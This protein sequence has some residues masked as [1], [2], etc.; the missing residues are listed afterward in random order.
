[1][2]FAAVARV[3]ESR[4]IACGVR[5]EINFGLVPGSEL[6]LR[7]TICYE[8]RE[9]GAQ[10]AIDNVAEDPLFCDHQTPRIYGF[11]SYISIPIIRQNGEFFG[12]LCAIDPQPNEVNNSKT[13]GLFKLFADLISHHLEN[14]EKL[15]A[16][17]SRL[18]EERSLSELREQFIAILG[19][20]LKN[21]ISAISNS[22]QLQLRMSSDE[23][24]LQ[25]AS[26]IKNSSYRIQGLIENMLDF[27]RGRMGSG[28]PLQLKKDRSLEAVLT[29][30]IAELRSIWPERGILTNFSI[31]EGV[32]CDSGRIAQ[33]FSN[34]LGNALAYGEPGEAV[35]VVAEI[36]MGLF[37]LSVTNTGKEIPAAVLRRIF[38][39]FTR[40]EITPGQQ[41][42]GLGLYIAAEIAKAHAGKL[43]VVSSPCETCFTL[44]FPVDC[45]KG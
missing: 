33:L 6:E 14:V 37:T 38:Q 44:T 20:D 3:T 4:W 22:A 16:S 41:G 13:I 43:E 24:I 15:A 26:I 34:L 7:T 40:G 18:L 35:R 19:H 42:L 30:V 27:A 39:P 28:I 36:R 10:V 29:E 25:L 45:G 32:R 21:P 9:S 31:T 2:G 17:E 12:T 5:D 1:M 8:I 23:D 11:Q